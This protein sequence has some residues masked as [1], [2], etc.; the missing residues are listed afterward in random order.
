VNHISAEIGATLAQT[1]VSGNGQ[2][3]S[4]YGYITTINGDN[5]YCADGN[6]N[7]GLFYTPTFNNSQNFSSSYVEFTSATVSVVFTNTSPLTLLNH[8]SPTNMAAIQSFNSGNPWVTLTGNGNLGGATDQAAVLKWGGLLYGSK[9][10]G[11]GF[12]LFD[13]AGP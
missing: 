13:V 12:G 9:L 1:F 11:G 8:D 6:G 5:T 2:N 3:A 4:I 10:S 7:C